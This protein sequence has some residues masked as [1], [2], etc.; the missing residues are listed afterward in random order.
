MSIVVVV[1]IVGAVVIVLVCA[2]V[3]VGVVV[4][5]VNVHDDI[6]VVAGIGDRVGDGVLNAS[7][8]CRHCRCQQCLCPRPCR[9]CYARNIGAE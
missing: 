7:L 2:N 3:S 8:C 4:I 5:V 9:C 1:V 6:V